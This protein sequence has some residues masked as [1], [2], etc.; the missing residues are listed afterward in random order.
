MALASGGTM[1]PYVK[2]GDTAGFE[3]G[4]VKHAEIDGTAIA[5]AN[6]DGEFFAIESACTHVG[7]PLAEG[8][9]EGSVLVC[10][11][12]GGRF[13]VRTGQVQRP[14]PRAAART[15]PVTVQGDAIYVEVP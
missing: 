1:S 12:H 5:V 15:F 13:D 10:P 3:P 9:L 8:E 6:V 11:W 7:G 2:V 14:P 4:T